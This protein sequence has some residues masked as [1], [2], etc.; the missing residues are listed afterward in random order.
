MN[1]IRKEHQRKQ[2]FEKVCIIYSR[3]LQRFIYTLT[4]RDRFAAEE[5][6]QNTMLG[7]LKGLNY[8]RDSAKMKSWIFSIAKAE[9]KRYYAASRPENKFGF[10][11]AAENEPSGPESVFDFTR[12]IEDKELVKN[13]IN[14]LTDEE[15]QLYILHY[16]YDLPLKEIAEI[17]NVNYSTIRSMHM[18]GMAKLRKQTAHQK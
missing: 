4:R 5:I 10:G 7:A 3:D 9:A 13:L 14:G 11:A 2:A 1:Q 15:Q 17:L 8:L 12:S 18:R 16:Y 6:Y